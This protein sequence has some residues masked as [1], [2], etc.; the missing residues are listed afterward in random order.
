MNSNLCI[1]ILICLVVILF[2]F[3]TKKIKNTGNLQPENFNEL[4]NIDMKN[5]NE[6]PGF[7]DNVLTNN[8]ETINGCAFGID[9]CDPKLQK[10]FNPNVSELPK[11]DNK[12]LQPKNKRDDWFS[13]LWLDITWEDANLLSDAIMKQG[14]NT[15]GS[16]LKNPTYDIR[17]N[18]PNPKFAVS[19][20]GNSWIEP[21]MNL[22][23]WC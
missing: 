1:V 7:D 18:I 12:E 20:W 14:I 19:P 16:S 21:D 17:G 15:I 2:F 6:Y 8:M 13:D 11:M 5:K 10:F 22:K 3:N 4:D 23:S 9:Q